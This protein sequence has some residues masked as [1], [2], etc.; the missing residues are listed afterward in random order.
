MN[1]EEKKN[2]EIIDLRVIFKKIRDNRKLYYKVL[3]IVFVLS[4]IYILSQPRYYSTEVKLAPEIENGMGNGTLGSIASS[5][6]FDLNSMQT[7]DAITPMLYP[8]LMD[9]NGFI[10]GMFSI[11]VQDQEGEINTTYYDYLKKYQKHSWVG[12]PLR[13]VKSLLPKPKDNKKESTDSKFEPYYLSRDDDNIASAIRN[14][15]AISIDNKTGVITISTKAQDA[16]ICKT[17]ADSI[18]DRLQAFITDYRTNKAR[19]DYDYYKQLTIEAKQDYEKARQRY[20]A[21][22]DGNVNIAMQSVR[23][24]AEE[25]ESEMELKLNNYNTMNTQM[26]AAKA[27]IQER[28]PAFTVIKGATVPIKPAG[29]KRMLFVLGMM[30]LFSLG[31][32]VWIV[33]S[34]IFGMRG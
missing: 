17:L 15:V 20:G 23:L 31:I 32:T 10:T 4:C 14:N 12:A 29:P 21:Y 3:P 34:D 9:D 30:I 27:K 24:K 2:A 7:S 8:D 18:K 22:I 26:Q 6:G 25:M 16:L 5:F 11:R 1:M 33:R 19:I 13:W 28:T